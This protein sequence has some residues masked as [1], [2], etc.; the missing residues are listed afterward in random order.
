MPELG[1]F[2]RELRARFWKPSVEDEVREEL[3]HHIE[4]L[5][6]ELVRHGLPLEAARRAARERFGD[7]ERIGAACRDLGEGRDGEARRSR[8]RRE[9]MH[10][11]RYALRQ[12]ARAPRFTLVA[13]LTLAVGLGA[14]TTIFGV[15]N[16]VLLRPL[17]FRE[18]SRLVLVDEVNGSGDAW[19]ISEPNYLDVRERSSSIAELGATD[20]RGLTMTGGAAPECLRGAAVTA[21]L[22]EVLGVAP[23]LGRGIAPDEELP[24]TDSRV[25]VLGDALWRRAFGA[26]P[27]VVGLLVELDGT[28]HRVVGVMPPGFDFPAGSEV[29]IPLAPDAAAERGDRRLQG[30]GRLAAGATVDRAEQEMSA[31]AA[32][33]ESEYPQSNSSWKARV[34]PFQELYVTPKLEARVVVLLVAVGLLVLMACINIASLL[35]ARAGTRRHE[36]AI[37]AALGAG[38]VRIVRQLLTESLVLAAIG[39]GLGVVLAAAATPLIRS[40]GSAA[41]PLLA[42]MTLDWRV[43]AFA[44]AAC[45]ATGIIFGLAPAIAVLRAAGGGGGGEASDLLRGGARVAGG[46]RLRSTLVACSVAMAM[47]MV[48]GAS[49]VVG[50]FMRLTRAE[51]GFSPGQ[52]LTASL[53]LPDARYDFDGSAE[54]FQELLPRLDALPGVQA[55]GA[56]NLAPFSGGNTA[57]DFVPGASAP[58]DPRDFHSASWRAVT[59]GYFAALGI[60]LLHGRLFDEHDLGGELPVMVINEAMARAAWPDSD[61]IGRQVTLANTRTMTVIG[62]VGDSRQLALDSLP[63]PAMYFAHAQFPWKTMWLTVRTSGDP[64]AL[65]PGIRRELSTLDAG[66]ALARAQPLDRL[67]HDMAAEP[68]LTT[69]VLGIFAGA[70]VVLVTVGLYGLVSYSVVQRTREIG[71]RVALGAPA[72]RIARSVVGRGVRLALIGVAAGGVV[73][74]WVGDLLRGLL[75]EMSPADPFTYAAAGALILAVAVA[76][77][78]IPAYRAARL[79]PL[80]AIRE[81]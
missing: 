40:V 34:R 67:V 53:V 68:R 7:V 62:I 17:P 60:P 51:L 78:A 37:R 66:L 56:V 23:R 5:E 57:M 75:Y 79:D 70:A 25:V 16:A 41:V 33:L 28:L 2:S 11:A 50:S 48:V 55:A 8:W 19:A 64:M 20:R 44:A 74:L 80:E 30:V 22:F 21:S 32:R 61:P 73:S 42:T 18:P 14:A 81:G 69:L 76:A 1:R 31:I 46:S 4:M 24:G 72:G 52:V 3:A 26:D 15:A 13:T 71:V 65:L 58:A 43:I 27:G 45:V 47:V 38:R 9:W 29:W 10:D 54:L 12:L 59:P 49:L 39:S 63:A 6:Q 35:L 36:L 77:S